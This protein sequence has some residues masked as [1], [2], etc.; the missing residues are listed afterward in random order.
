MVVSFSL[1]AYMYISRSGKAG[2]Y[3]IFIDSSIS[4]SRKPP[5]YDFIFLIA[6]MKY[7]IS[8]NSPTDPV[9]HEV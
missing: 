7:F 3:G 8:G 4:F 9:I 5:F 2:S 1:D 6:Y